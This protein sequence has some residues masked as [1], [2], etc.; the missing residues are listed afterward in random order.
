MISLQL[1]TILQY[2]QSP[3]V[4]TAWSVHSL[5]GGKLIPVFGVIMSNVQVQLRGY[6]QISP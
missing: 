1:A 3:E 6:I 2:S 5:Q 4:D